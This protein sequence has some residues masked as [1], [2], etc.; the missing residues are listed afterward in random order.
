[1]HLTMMNLVGVDLD[2]FGDSDGIV[3]ELLQP[4]SL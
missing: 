3:P 2:K 4:A 1:V